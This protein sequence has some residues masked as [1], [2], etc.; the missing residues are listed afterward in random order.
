MRIIFGLQLDETAYP[1]AQSHEQILSENGFLSWLEQQYGW[2]P[3]QKQEHLRIEQFRQLLGIYLNYEPNA[4]FEASFRTDSLATAQRLLDMW[5]TLRLAG[6]DFSPQEGMP[7]RLRVFS[8]LWQ[9]NEGEN[10][11]VAEGFVERFLRIETALNLM[12]IGVLK[13]VQLNE[14]LDFYPAHWKRVFSLLEAQQIQ[15]LP[16]PNQHF[17]RLKAS[18]NTDLWDFQT[19]ILQAAAPAPHAPRADG[20]LLL[21]KADNERSAANFCA[22]LFKQNPRFRPLI[23]TQQKNR[24]L[25]M[26]FIQHGLPSLGIVS[27]S[28]ARPTLQLLKLAT[29]FLWKPV[30]PYKI[31][32]FLSLPN[33]PFHDGFAR[34][35]GLVLAKHPGLFGES[36]SAGVARFLGNFDEL[37]E[38]EP[39]R[40]RHWRAEKEKAQAPYNFWFRRYRY[41]AGREQVPARVVVELFEYIQYWA[42]QEA[43]NY[44]ERI[45]KLEDRIEKAN[46]QKSPSAQ[47]QIL[48]RQREEL[49]QSQTPLLNLHQQADKL[50]QVLNTLPKN[51]NTLSPLELERLIRTLNEPAPFAFRPA[52]AQHLDYVSAPS[53]ILTPVESV[54]WW[55]FVQPEQPNLQEFWYP[56]EITYLEAQNVHFPSLSEQYKCRNW[57]EKIPVLMADNQLILVVPASVDGRDTNPHPFWEDLNAIFG[58]SLE[59]ITYKIA[60]FWSDNPEND[61]QKSLI[62]KFFQ[63]PEYA[64]LT[65]AFFS[66]SNAYLELTQTD[67]LT[68]REEESFTSLNDLIYA[69]YEWVFKNKL[70]L[71]KSAILSV[72]SDETL[73][74]NLAHIIL[75][76]LLAPETPE[77]AADLSSKKTLS[78]WFDKHWGEFIE[79]EAANFN[80]YG[81]ETELLKFKSHIET[82]AWALVVAIKTNHWEVAGCE[83]PIEGE[84]GGQKLIGT[85]DL[86]LKR[87]QE[88]AVIDLKWARAA[89]LQ[90]K[91]KNEQD[92]Q[93]VIYSKLVHPEQ[94]WAHTA[95]FSLQDAK[96]S[97]RNRLG[98]KQAEVVGKIENFEAVH[99]QIWK[100]IENTYL[101]RMA[102][103]AEGQVEI[104]ANLSAAN[105]DEDTP[106]MEDILELQTGDNSFNRTYKIL[107]NPLE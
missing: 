35:L 9:I 18:K 44:V 51:A 85:A 10:C 11:L 89:R 107:I 68:P 58:K 61:P 37:I 87:G 28:L 80:L 101:W 81:Q 92:L 34:E 67:I 36:W 75:K 91:I 32:E 56:K 13:L 60:N 102:Q 46:Y 54:F 33:K 25:D 59:H 93:L 99:A 66:A 22:H 5:D 73:K 20:S 7:D 78:A 39:Q 71:R 76:N 65:P 90:E 62:E 2:Q 82:A 94:G 52:E 79:T 26:A 106:N 63:I 48:I 96:L 45:R 1:K 14:P 19:Q 16:N 98:F 21:L 30:D 86:V 49:I 88:W 55:G 24:G 105:Q 50:I 70:E 47:T 43:E 100:K 29:V 41:T 72:T 17:E 69:P 23:Y 38:K 27:A 53:A 8:G 4:F 3:A 104:Q 77:K 74:G 40:A 12:P 84:L 83:L 103:L 64:A 42:M 15:I 57:Q 95:Y 97:A 31:L 6:W